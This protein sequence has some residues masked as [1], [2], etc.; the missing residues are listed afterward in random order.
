MEDQSM[1]TAILVLGALTVIVGIAVFFVYGGGFRAGR[2]GHP[3]GQ[4][5]RSGQRVA[6]GIS[7]PLMLI[8]SLLSFG[9]LLL[10]VALLMA[11]A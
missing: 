9:T 8:G 2:P 6:G 7:P 1:G 10:L 4:W 11:I 5:G 3:E